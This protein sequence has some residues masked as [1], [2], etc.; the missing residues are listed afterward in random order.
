MSNRR[1]LSLWFPRLGAERLLRQ[2]RGRLEAPLAVVAD[3]HNMQVLSSV[4]QAA[5]KAGLKPGMA[6]RDASAIAPDLIT[7]P[8][9]EPAEAMF[10]AGLRRWAGKYSPWVAEAPPDGLVIDLTGCAHLFGGEAALME[11]AAAD[12]IDLGLSVQAG[13]ADTLGAAWAI[14]RF[15]TGATP[16][17]TGDAIDQEAYATRARAG[18]RRHWTRGGSAPAPRAQGAMP[19]RIA[20]PGQTRTAIAGLP[21]TALRLEPAAI[22]G[23]ARL[24]VRQIGDLAGLP[25]AATTRRFGADV[26]MRLD[27]ALGILPEPVAPARPPDHFAV[28]LSLPDPIG[29]EADILAGID[30]LLEPLCDQ[31]RDRG[32]GARRIRLQAMRVDAASVGVEVGLARPSANPDRIRPLLALKL[33]EIDAG[34]GID[35]LRLTAPVTEPVHAVQHAGHAEAAARGS[36]V[37]AAQAEGTGVDDLIGRLG[38]RI[39]LD[40]I[41]RRH[42]ADSHAPEKNATIMGAAWSDPAPEWPA[43][44]AARPLMLWPPEPVMAP[45]DPMPPVEFRWRRA[46]HKLAEARGPERIAPEWWL[47][48]PNWRS[49]LRDYW[50]VVTQGG[51]RLWFYY[52][53]GGT[54]SGGWFAQGRFA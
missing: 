31:L 50:Q 33:G 47:D 6:L 8:R 17:R 51:D 43:P 12:C 26:V 39:G 40:A 32:R 25:R 44:P 11:Q 27:Q 52:A 2:D 20:P 18:K 30:R 53:H 35:V 10:L 5:A 4:S 7:R 21:I 46:T 23:L 54:M 37:M 24:G 15:S 45:D 1:I 29:L 48:D 13:I 22:A 9:D 3:D 16:D 28:R 49:G 14:A 19:G 34:F 38:A 41:T 36:A 42:P